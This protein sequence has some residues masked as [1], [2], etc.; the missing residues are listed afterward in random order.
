MPTTISGRMK[1]GGMRNE[2]YY[3]SHVPV[4]QLEGEN[5]V[6]CGG[7]VIVIDGGLLRR[8]GM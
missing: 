3:Q 1:G 4:H 6:K 7:K 2:R 8:T 5:P